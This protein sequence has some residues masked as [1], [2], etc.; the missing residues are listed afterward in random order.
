[1]TPQQQVRDIDM[2]WRAWAAWFARQAKG[3]SVEVGIFA[4]DVAAYAAANE[5]G[6][7]KIPERSFIRSTFDEERA[8]LTRMMD[9]A[10]LRAQTVLIPLA[11]AL[12]PAAN[13]L[14]NAIIRKITSSP[15][16]PNAPATVAA[17]GFNAPLV[18]TGQLQ[19]ALTWRT[20]G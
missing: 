3:G 16:P 19:R 20:V 5:F 11:D 4:P 12:I 14:R 9:A 7:S 1:M 15:P 8:T 10:A 2:G 17:K 6:T 13:H 18:N